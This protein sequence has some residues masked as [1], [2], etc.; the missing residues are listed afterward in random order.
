ML[1]PDPLPMQPGGDPTIALPAKLFRKFLH[2]LQ[3][4]RIIRF[5]LF[6]LVVITASR[7]IHQF[8]SP[9]DP[10]EEVSVEMRECRFS[11]EV[12]GFAAQLF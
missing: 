6:G 7:Q 1:D 3:E 5:L 12:R 10:L 11:S 4:D 8:A 2:T 9:L